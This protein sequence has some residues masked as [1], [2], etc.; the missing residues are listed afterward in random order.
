MDL[1]DFWFYCFVLF[2][3]QDSQMVH[4]YDGLQTGLSCVC[5]Q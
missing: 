3:A 5:K 1:L 4:C 2:V